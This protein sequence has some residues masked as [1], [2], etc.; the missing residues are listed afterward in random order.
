MEGSGGGV[1]LGR[2]G[3]SE[4]E[5]GVETQGGGTSLEGPC[6]MIL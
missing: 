2:G 4:Y 6:F 3:R 5:P 1:D